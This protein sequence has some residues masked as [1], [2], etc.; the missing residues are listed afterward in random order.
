MYLFSF[1][2]LD[3]YVHRPIYVY[4]FLCKSYM[5]YIC[6]CYSYVFFWV[7]S[8]VLF[9]INNFMIRY[10]LLYIWLKNFI[11]LPLAL[12]RWIYFDIIDIVGVANSFCCYLCETLAMPVKNSPMPIGLVCTE[13]DDLIIETLSC[14]LIVQFF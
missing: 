7:E 4:I 12:Y 8:L 3:V 2:Y 13:D 9:M 5:V 10:I 1:V 14:I 11:C 6:I